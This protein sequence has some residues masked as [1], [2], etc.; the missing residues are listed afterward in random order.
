MFYF[1]CARSRSDPLNF[2]KSAGSCRLCATAARIGP[3]FT[4]TTNHFSPR[5]P[6]IV[7]VITA[8]NRF[9]TTLRTPVLAV[10]GEIYNHQAL[11]QQ[12][13]RP[14]CVQTSSDL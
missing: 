9:N 10:N 7:G 11:R 1:R 3:A 5:T 12:L 6:S 2:V 8:L 4:P 13:R 14:L